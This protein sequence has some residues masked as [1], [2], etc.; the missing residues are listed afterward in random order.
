MKPLL[1]L[2]LTVVLV[3]CQGNPYTKFYTEQ[4]DPKTQPAVIPTTTPLVIY[5]SQD[6]N[7]DNYVMLRKGYGRIGYSS[8]VDVNCCW[9]CHGSGGTTYVMRRTAYT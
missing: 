8:F 7:K 1:L 5:T 3:G 9:A 4:V 6:L 2:L